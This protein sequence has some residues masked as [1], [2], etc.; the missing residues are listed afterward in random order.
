MEYANIYA[1]WIYSS[2]ELNIIK[3]VEEMD[4]LDREI[5][6]ALLGS[7]R[8]LYALEKSLEVSSYPT[9]HRH[10]KELQ[11]KELLIIRRGQLR[12]DGKIDQRKTGIPELTPKGLATLLI[13][14]DLEEEELKRAVTKTLQ[15]DFALLPPTFLGTSNVDKIFSDTLLRMRP[16]INL[17]FFDENY[18]NEVF[19]VSL[20]Q[21][22]LENFKDFKT[23]RS[24]IKKKEAMKLRKKY[25]SN[26]T[27]EDFRKL[28]K[29][30]KNESNKFKQYSNV[31]S[32]VIQTLSN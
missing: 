27:I 26:Q 11:E 16:K 23:P 24:K 13:E 9:I 7:H 31:M 29:T 30:F 15:K 17:K 3:E 2:C 6:I 21:S 25:I 32:K 28:Q 8:S 12:K 18:F 10:T 4:I 19:N 22:I 14:G 1:I 20:G 5:L